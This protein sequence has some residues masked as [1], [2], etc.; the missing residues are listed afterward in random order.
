[1]LG[2]SPGPLRSQSSYPRGRSGRAPSR[3]AAMRG[4]RERARLGSVA[5]ERGCAGGSE[6]RDVFTGACAGGPARD[7]RDRAARA[8]ARRPQRPQPHSVPLQQLSD[9]GVVALALLLRRG[10]GSA[11]A[12]ALCGKSAG[13]GALGGGR[14]RGGARRYLLHALVDYSWDFLAVTAPTMFALGVLAAAG[15]P[16]R[17]PRAAASLR[18]RGGGAGGTGRA[19]VV[20]LAAAGRS[21]VRASTRALDE[22]DFERAGIARTWARLLNPYSPS[23]PCS[24]RSPRIE[25]PSEPTT[26]STTWTRS[27]SSPRTRR[28]G[29]RSGS[30]SSRAQGADARAYRFLNEA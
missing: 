18:R 25:E 20:R 5:R 28:R 30:S 10:A 29:T 15:R 21:R 27:S 11:C 16:A 26:R 22:G 24:S 3:R 8:P 9:G 17:E 12:R 13:R 2:R 4:G 6:A 23:S 19:R 14:A 1:M 7:V